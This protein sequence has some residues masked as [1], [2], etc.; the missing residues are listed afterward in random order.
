MT[1]SHMK[2]PVLLLF[3]VANICLA[4]KNTNED[5]RFLERTE[6]IKINL[7]K[8]TFNIVKSIHEKAEYVTAN[9][10]YFANEVLHFDSFTKLQ[11][12][13][14]T[15]YL[16]VSGKTLEV[17]YIET[18]HEFDDGIFYSDQQTKNFTFP[19]VTKGAITDLKYKEIISEPHFLGLFR[20][21]TY[22]PT[23]KAILRIEFPKNVE[24]GYKEFHTENITIDFK[25]EETKNS[26]I[27]TWT[28]ENVAKFMSEDDDGLDVDDDDVDV[29]VL[30]LQYRT[31]V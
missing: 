21:G 19:G 1:I 18:K 9:K 27:Y 6:D 17:D 11:D 7:K 22:A 16:P 20:F 26:N 3:F 30:S 25:K 5:F 13:E 4:Q 29:P 8:G 24:I 14:A 23:Q 2:F 10:L 12:I 31:L 15:T 28:T